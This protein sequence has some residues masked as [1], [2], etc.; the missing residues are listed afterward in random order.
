MLICVAL[1]SFQ[2]LLFIS[3]CSGACVC[4]ATHYCLVICSYAYAYCLCMRRF[5]FRCLPGLE[6]A[7]RIMG[8]TEG[9][10][11]QCVELLQEGNILSISPGVCYVLSVVII[12]LCHGDKMII[13]FIMRLIRIIVIHP[14]T[15]IF[16]ISTA[17]C[18]YDT[19]T[20]YST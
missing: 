4:C 20:L 19:R 15:R 6:M 9:S 14:Y 12:M 3:V 5:V 13:S 16:A 2:C 8:A 17:S 18:E 7:F 1:N 10:F 11:D